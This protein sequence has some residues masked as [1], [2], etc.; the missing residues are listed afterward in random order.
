MGTPGSRLEGRWERRKRGK[1]GK[2]WGVVWRISGTGIASER[3]AVSYSFYETEE[4]HA[5]ALKS[6]ILSLEY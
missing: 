5:S 1:Q 2:A 4:S 6:S 3:V